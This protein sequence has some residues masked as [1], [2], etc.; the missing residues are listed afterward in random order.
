MQLL[1][2]SHM[3]LLSI[4]LILSILLL[5]PAPTPTLSPLPLLPLPPG[6]PAQHREGL[7][8]RGLGGEGCVRSGELCGRGQDCL[9]GGNYI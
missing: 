6:V 1:L 2:L 7:R 4:L 5:H 8:P 9:R 3:L